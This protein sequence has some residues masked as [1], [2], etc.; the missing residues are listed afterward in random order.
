[1]DKE[2]TEALDGEASLG[3]RLPTVRGISASRRFNSLGPVLRVGLFRFARRS[4]SLWMGRRCRIRRGRADAQSLGCDAS[5]P[6]RARG[7]RAPP[8]RAAAVRSSGTG[9]DRR[10][11]DRGRGRLHAAAVAAIRPELAC[12]E[13]QS[14]ADEPFHPRSRRHR[15]IRQRRAGRRRR[16]LSRSGLPRAPGRGDVRAR[17]YRARRDSA[18]AAGNAVRQ[19][20]DG[21]CGQHGHQAAALRSL[22]SD[23]GSVRRRLR[24]PSGQDVDLGPAR[25][26]CRRGTHQHRGHGS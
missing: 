9:R 21:G 22:G 24:V 17:R 20:H 16:R 7:Y 4:N 5:R 3:R 10:Q 23:R 18:R 12:R 2:P 6:R 26:R 1:M 25:R 8:R 11:Q 13:L 19:K 14:S 15:R